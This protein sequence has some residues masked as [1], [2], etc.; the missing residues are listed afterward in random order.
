[1]LLL[2]LTVHINFRQLVIFAFILNPD[3]GGYALVVNR[4]PLSFLSN[5]TSL[6]L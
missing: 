1:M 5:R 6:F 2:M 3:L 4:T